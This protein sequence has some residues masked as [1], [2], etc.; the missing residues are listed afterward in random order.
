MFRGI[1]F[2]EKPLVGVRLL[3]DFSR[4]MG[5]EGLIVTILAIY[6]EVNVRAVLRHRDFQW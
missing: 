5:H 3:V 6:P 1:L 2:E 4:W